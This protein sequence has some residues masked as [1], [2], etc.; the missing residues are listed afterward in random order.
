MMPKPRCPDSEAPPTTTTATHKSNSVL[1]PLSKGVISEA[2]MVQLRKKSI[3]Y[4]DAIKQREALNKELGLTSTPAHANEADANQSTRTAETDLS[5]GAEPNCAKENLCRSPTPQHTLPS[6]PHHVQQQ[7]YLSP[8]PQT[9]PPTQEDNQTTMNVT[10][11]TSDDEDDDV[12]SE[13]EGV[14]SLD[15]N[16]F[17]HCS[18][19]P[20][21]KAH[22]FSVPPR[23]LN[24]HLDKASHGDSLR[25]TR[26]SVK[27][28][29]KPRKDELTVEN[30][31][32]GPGT[33]NARRRRP[34]LVPPIITTTPAEEELGC[35]LTKQVSVD[36]MGGRDL[37]PCPST[38]SLQGE[39]KP[40]KKK[41]SVAAL[42]A[43]PIPP[44]PVGLQP[45]P[46]SRSASFSQT[47]VFSDNA[48]R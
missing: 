21:K 26:H 31:A 14:A 38:L 33:L 46:L 45:P 17:N 29:P 1:K 43:V 36:S 5:V 15:P 24:L 20:I 34:A 37:S 18:P 8:E 19:S 11:G 10:L 23:H 27:S 16:R 48:L 30:T 32:G 39:S 6:P 35:I 28:P 3:D 9:P 25:V 13:K 40:R 22:S 4:H 47:N 7:P 42:E 12:L 41:V 44:T 2:K